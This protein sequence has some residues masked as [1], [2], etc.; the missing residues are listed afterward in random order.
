MQENIAHLYEHGPTQYERGRAIED[1]ATS[2]PLRVESKK[3]VAKPGQRAV[4]PDGT[5]I[6]LSDAGKWEPV[7]AD[8][9][10]PEPRPEPLATKPQGGPLEPAVEEEGGGLIDM[11]AKALQPVDT[12]L[13]GIG[14][15]DGYG[16]SDTGEYV[17]L[18]KK[19]PM[20][21]S[22]DA[23][24]WM[25]GN[26]NADAPLPADQRPEP[27]RPFFTLE[28]YLY[29]EMGRDI[30]QDVPSQ[31]AKGAAT[32]PEDLFNMLYAKPLSAV[33]W[34]GAQGLSQSLDNTSEQRASAIND[35]LPSAEHDTGASELLANLAQ[36]AGAGVT[37]GVGGANIAKKAGAVG[38]SL[39]D[40]V[41]RQGA[42]VSG[43]TAAETLAHSPD[44]TTLSEGIGLVDEN[45]SPSN[46]RTLAAI[47]GL[48]GNIAGE[49][50]MA[51]AKQVA[52]KMAPKADDLATKA[53]ADLD[54]DLEDVVPVQEKPSRV[55]N[56]NAARAKQKEDQALLKAEQ[57]TLDVDSP[58]STAQQQ[59]DLPLEQPKPKP[60]Q[61]AKQEEL[62]PDDGQSTLFPKGPQAAEPLTTPKPAE[63]PKLPEAPD[64]PVKTVA[65]RGQGE[66]F[67]KT[68]QARTGDLY[69]VTKNPNGKGHVVKRR[70]VKL[71]SMPFADPAIIKQSAPELMNGAV[72]GTV[73]NYY[74][75]GELGF[76]PEFFAAGVLG[77]TLGYRTPV[78]G[79]GK[80][81]F[82]KN[83]LAEVARGKLGEGLKKAAPSLHKTNGVDEVLHD[84]I[85]KARVELDMWKADAIKMAKHINKNFSKEEREMMSDWIE[86]QYV[87]DGA[88]AKRGG[89]N[90]ID[91]RVKEQAE[92]LSKHSDEMGQKLV[93]YGMLS[94]EAYDG[95]KGRYLHR[96]YQNTDD[97]R[98]NWWNPL[99]KQ[100]LKADYAKGRGTFNTISANGMK[101]GDKVTQMSDPASGKVVYARSDG[102]KNTLAAKGYIEGRQFEVKS[103]TNGKASI[104]ADYNIVQ[105]QQ[106]KEI[107]DAS[108]RSA[109]GEMEAAHDLVYGKLFAELAEDPKWASNVEK[110]GWKQLPAGK[111]SG[112]G[113]PGNDFNGVNT[114]GKLAGKW[115]HPD[116]ERAIT[117]ARKPWTDEEIGGLNKAFHAYKGLLTAWKVG[118]TAYNPATHMNNITSN[119]IMGMLTGTITP[120]SIN[121]ARKALKNDEALMEAQAA[122]LSIGKGH[123]YSEEA[124]R[125][126]KEVDDLDPEL[127][128]RGFLI[129]MY[130]AFLDNPVTGLYQYEDDIFKM[131]SYLKLK[132]DGLSPEE[133]VKET[134][135]YF[136]DYSDL[137]PGAQI[138]RDT[139]IPFVSYA[140]KVAPAMAE[141]AAT[142]PHALIGLFGALGG[143]NM[144]SYGYMY[145][146]G[147]SEQE[148]LERDNKPAWQQGGPGGLYDVRLPWNKKDQ[149]RP[150]EDR[151][152]YANI[153]N[154]VPGGGLLDFTNNSEFGPSLWPQVF[155][156]VFGANPVVNTFVSTVALEKDLYFGKDIYPYPDVDILDGDWDWRR[157]ENIKALV[158]FTARQFAPGFM[159]S[160]N[161]I[162]SASLPDS[163]KDSGLGEFMGWN[164]TD[165]A[166]RQLQTWQTIAGAM[167]LKTNEM[168]VSEAED[169][170]LSSLRKR[171]RDAKTGVMKASRSQKGTPGQIRSRKQKARAH[172]KAEQKNTNEVRQGK[173]A[174]RDAAPASALPESQRSLGGTIKKAL[175]PRGPLTDRIGDLFKPGQPDA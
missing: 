124:A 13:G 108:Y 104:H 138:I 100:K 50:G 42:E 10:T 106:M 130:D 55:A 4:M 78:T 41:T 117:T 172:L 70:P 98:K 60:D 133:A 11:I 29:G 39:G 127:D 3:Q 62:L 76:S 119:A 156:S 46:T 165:F 158:Q 169:F 26:S 23:E 87:P 126:T 30:L 168:T 123:Q 166:G 48:I 150:G 51:G 37:G 47:E 140:Y 53:D 72:A 155:G 110:E 145:G 18:P 136:F 88:T 121:Q 103:V 86:Q 80:T 31:L 28:N 131:A 122:G 85:N 157:E 45:Q 139:A 24:N 164:G 159:Y 22:P 171:M 15:P 1:A 75:T 160:T 175:T 115:V 101:K 153:R 162:L 94:K 93:D 67:A 49:L 161:K 8:T 174:L 134:H 83:S 69:E 2:L 118:K 154:M 27:E 54:A 33:G 143:I 52:G 167:G 59:I 19:R 17:R 120:T 99:V 20:Y 64:K 116:V 66:N 12:Y 163:V 111:I 57:Q 63:Q 114:Y 58:N 73:G 170:V 142:R 38:K 74:A 43:A 16:Y 40:R 65:T 149:A 79:S 125:L 77:T 129:K 151:A 91:S 35:Y 113:T 84:R 128:Q 82:G 81:V 135:K 68:Q 36:F 132:G 92:L 147:A 107:R 146:D 109:R 137:P 6:K 96:Y 90:A 44:Q 56:Y 148:A 71:Y 25:A 152:M 102:Q 173:K 7:D 95:L 32:A 141:I 14:A 9:P 144:M 89:L 105:R 5:I 34:P 21:V 112:T 97:K 61:V